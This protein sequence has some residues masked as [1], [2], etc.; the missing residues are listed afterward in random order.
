MQ[1]RTLLPAAPPGAVP[2][3]KEPRGSLLPFCP[4]LSTLERGAALHRRGQAVRVQDVVSPLLHVAPGGVDDV[5]HRLRVLPCEA[6][7]HPPVLPGAG[8][9]VLRRPT[10]AVAA[11]R[12]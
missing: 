8:Q 4:A 6:L 2:S 11:G 3:E 10:E 9:K 12:E 5:L 1:D 7:V